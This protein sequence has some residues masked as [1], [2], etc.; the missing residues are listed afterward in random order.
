[1]KGLLLVALVFMV[2]MVGI[3]GVSRVAAVDHP[4]L[5][6]P[7]DKLNYLIQKADEE[8]TARHSLFCS[9]CPGIPDTYLV[10]G[11]QETDKAYTLHISASARGTDGGFEIWFRDGD[12]MP[13]LIPKGNTYSTSQAL[14]GV[15][16]VDTPKVMIV[17]TGGVDS[18]MASVLAEKGTAF[19]KNCTG[20]VDHVN[21]TGTPGVGDPPICTFP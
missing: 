17:P 19:C 5:F 18:M 11:T 8:A 7:G 6:T 13:F 21:H 2:S 10:C 3:V 20:I 14:G 15:P 12:V 1:M 16:N 4:E 9:D